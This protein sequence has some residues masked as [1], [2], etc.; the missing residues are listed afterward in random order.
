MPHDLADKVQKILETIPISFR[1]PGGAVAVLK[2]GELVAEKVWGYANLSTRTPITAET[3]MPICSITKQ[4]TC[5]LLHDLENNTPP[6]VAA[7]GTFQ[8]QMEIQLKEWLPASLTGSSGLTI[9]HLCD[10]QSGLRDYWAVSMICGAKPDQPF[11]IE[12][13]GMKMISK[14]KTFHFQPGSEFSYSNVNFFVLA[15]LIERITKQP[16]PKLLKERIF[17]PRN[18][19]TAKLIPDTAKHPGDCLGYEG[20]EEYGFLPATNRIEWSGDAG[21]TASLN[22]MIAYEKDFD[23]RW[24]SKGQYYKTASAT[25]YKDGNPASYSYGMGHLKIGGDDGVDTVGHAGALRGWRMQRRYV[26]KERMSVIVLFNS[27]NLNPSKAIS[28]IVKGALDLPEPPSTPAVEP[29]ESWFGDFLDEDTQLNISVSKGDEGQIVV[30]YARDKE[31]IRLVTPT[32]AKNDGNVASIEGDTLKIHRVN[33]NRHL[34]A[35]RVQP[36]VLTDG[37]RLQGSYKCAE[38]ESTFVVE[39]RD[40]MLY[41]AFDGPLGQGPANLM[42]RLGE[43]VWAWNCPRA[44]DHTPPGDWTIVFTEKEGV[45]SGVTIGCWLARR[46]EFVKV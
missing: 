5:A 15:R 1:G 30:V 19:T 23:Q 29:V 24:K 8:E 31:N 27:E 14:F 9:R 41:G 13:D 32:Q 7:N 4:M 11:T 22:D 12:G 39:G 38:L 21:V 17:R 44:L 6:E 3:L 36:E 35:K 16:L 2:D 40:N 25:T 26:V 28:L 34:V 20:N 42:K 46:L 10:M 33:E 43:N 18:M 45:I 37:S